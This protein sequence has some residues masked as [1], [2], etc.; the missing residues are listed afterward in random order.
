MKPARTSIHSE[1]Y[2]TASL[3][4]LYL[5]A[6]MLISQLVT[7]DGRIFASQDVKF[8]HYFGRDTMF[9]ASFIADTYHQTRNKQNQILFEKAKKAVLTFWDFQTKEGKIP[10][11]IK[12]F[13][14]NENDPLYKQGFYYK[15]GN[16]LVNNESIDA[17]PLTLITTAAYIKD[18]KKEID[19]LKPQ[20][21][22]ALLWMVTNMDAHS[23]WLSYFPNFKGLICQGWMDSYW[24]VTDEKG[25]VPEGPIALVE[26]QAYVWKALLVWADLLDQ[27]TVETLQLRIVANNLRER[28][29]KAFLTD[30]L[31]PGGERRK[32]FAHAID[33]NKKQIDT[34]SIN[35]GLCLWAT[36]GNEPF[37]KKEYIDDLIAVIT[38]KHLFHEKGGIRTFSVEEPTF[39]PEYYHSGK[40]V[41]WP[42]ATGLVAQGIIALGESYYD[43]GRS[44]MMANL[45]SMLHF[46]SFVEHFILKEEDETY[47]LNPHGI[48]ANCNNQTWTVAAFWWMIHHPVLFEQVANEIPEFDQSFDFAAEI[49]EN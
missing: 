27:E 31:L 20:I 1:F 22:K 8:H 41:F 25:N 17:T 49:V 23:G 46:Q 47:L 37:I 6:G 21:I 48:N 39:D 30:V 3:N 34:M 11:E 15:E 7:E 12:P 40:H 2:N 19:R 35:P 38:S 10:H 43:S 24:G 14:G 42:F 45:R 28:F 9:T 32:Y 33:G 16:F 4:Q 5:H 44:I 18:D 26:V 36:Y 13:E 29:H